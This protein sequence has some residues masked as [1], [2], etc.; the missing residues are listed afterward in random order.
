MKKL[1]K[2]W[3]IRWMYILGGVAVL[4]LIMTFCVKK[5]L[6]ISL[7]DADIFTGVII[8]VLALAMMVNG[9]VEASHEQSKDESKNIQEPMEREK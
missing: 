7:H 2:V 8:A 3:W 6:L 1:W 5:T 9:M 4:C